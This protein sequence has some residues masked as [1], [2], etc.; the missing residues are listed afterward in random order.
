MDTSYERLAIQY[1]VEE[2]GPDVI[3]V[4]KKGEETSFLLVVPHLRANATTTPNEVLNYIINT[5]MSVLQLY[6]PD[7][8]TSSL[9]HHYIINT[10]MSALQ[11]YTPDFLTMICSYERQK[12]LL[13][14][15]ENP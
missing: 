2:G 6:T 8:I 10:R 15:D 9:H 4:S 1:L 14:G 13:G 5:R 3:Q 7:F 12:L 11:L